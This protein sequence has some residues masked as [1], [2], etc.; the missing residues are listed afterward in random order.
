MNHHERGEQVFCVCFVIQFFFQHKLRDLVVEAQSRGEEFIAIRDIEA[1]V[2]G[3]SSNSFK[4]AARVIAINEKSKV[5][6]HM[7]S[8]TC[9]VQ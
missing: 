1:A 5:D 9:S 2:V 7:T 3:G 8:T 4:A 6:G